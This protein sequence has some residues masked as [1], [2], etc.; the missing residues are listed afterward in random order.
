MIFF[1][2]FIYFLLSTS[3]AEKFCVNCKHFKSTLLSSNIFGKCSVFPREI[4][5]KMD[6]LVIG[7]AKIEYYYCSTVRLK[8]DMCGPTGKYYEKKTNFFR[9]ITCNNKNN[10]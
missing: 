7:K 2:Q 4:E 6:Y 1:I 5:N 9:K 8:E 3:N 10:D